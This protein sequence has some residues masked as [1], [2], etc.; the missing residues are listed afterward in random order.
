MGGSSS[1]SHGY[2]IGAYPKINIIQK[3]SFSVDGNATDVGDLTQGRD[4]F[5]TGKSPTHA[6]AAGGSTFTPFS[7]YT[8]VIDKFPFAVDANA[9]DVGDTTIS[10]HY[11]ADGCSSSTHGYALAGSDPGAPSNSY[12]GIEKYPFASDAN[13]TDVGDLNSSASISASCSSS[14]TEGFVT[15]ALQDKMI[16]FSFATDASSEFSVQQINLS[17]SDDYDKHGKSKAG[18]SSHTHGYS[19]GGTWG[20]PASN[21]DTIQKYSYTQGSGATTDVGNLI[22]TLSGGAG[23]I[24]V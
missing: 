6:Y 2:A 18:Q 13:S 7:S 17:G 15:P 16:K 22:Q 19:S 4:A 23:N 3:F 20:S 1:P 24:M 12:K 21:S 14:M 11:W 10:G 8:N 9:T 5:S